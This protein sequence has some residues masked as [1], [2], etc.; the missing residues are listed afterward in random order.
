MGTE[1]G[2]TLGMLGL[3]GMGI[4]P[5]PPPLPGVKLPELLPPELPPL[6]GLAG[7][8]GVAAG[9]LGWAVGVLVG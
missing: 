6:P 9:V 8:L 7:V 5:G 1:V 4:K 3:V 2:V